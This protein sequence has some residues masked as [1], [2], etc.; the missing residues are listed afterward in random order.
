MSGGE[1]QMRNLSYAKN[2]GQIAGRI[3]DLYRPSDSHCEAGGG[4]SELTV[5]P[6]QRVRSGVDDVSRLLTGTGRA[7]T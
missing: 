2:K 5:P 3:V 4:I 7:E 1:V 6:T